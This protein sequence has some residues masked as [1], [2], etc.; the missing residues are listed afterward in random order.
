MPEKLLPAE[1]GV[2]DEQFAAHG[3][4]LR[5]QHVLSC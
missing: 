1:A 2:A 4:P 3:L 5:W